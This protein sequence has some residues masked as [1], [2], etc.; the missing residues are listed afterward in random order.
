MLKPALPL[1]IQSL[2][3]VP[4]PTFARTDLLAVFATGLKG[5][6]QPANVKPGE[7]TRLNT[8]IAPISLANQDP[9]GVLN[10]TDLADFPN[11]RRLVDDVVDIELPVAEGI[12][13]T[14]AVKAATAAKGVDT[15]CGTNIAP[16]INGSKF[17]DGARS[18]KI[19]VFDNRFPYLKTPLA[20]SPN[21]TTN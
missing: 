4:A 13:C 1:L 15:G 19:A 11:G 14:A 6:N 5:L 16:A 3:G 2:F 9:L 20:N 17:T 8:A 7:M 12:L 18:A 10:L 21:G